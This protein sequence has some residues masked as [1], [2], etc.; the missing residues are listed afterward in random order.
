[1]LDMDTVDLD[2]TNESE[3]VWTLLTFAEE[4]GLFPVILPVVCKLNDHSIVVMGGTCI[5]E[6]GWEHIA[7]SYI[8]KLGEGTTAQVSDVPEKYLID[9]GF[10]RQTPTFRVAAEKTTILAPAITENLEFTLLKVEIHSEADARA[11]FSVLTYP[12]TEE[13]AN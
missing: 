7:D 6:D 3:K 10:M 2:N 12:R 4:E 1:M 9:L 11:E 5:G 8:L 13:T